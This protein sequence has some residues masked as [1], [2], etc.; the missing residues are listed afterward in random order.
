MSY[1]T[2]WLE[3]VYVGMCEQLETLTE[4][5]H[6]REMMKTWEILW[7]PI[8]FMR[9]LENSKGG[10]LRDGFRF[11]TSDVDT[12]FW[13]PDHKVICDP[14]QISI[15]R[16]PQYTVILMEYEGVPPGSTKLRLLTP[17][18]DTKINSLNWTSRATN[19]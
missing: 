19:Q 2:R 11:K 16:I 12:M 5:R 13:P 15:Y 1:N 7:R 3:S 9:G 10:S 8:N 14:S 4:V 17:S 6:R 18:G